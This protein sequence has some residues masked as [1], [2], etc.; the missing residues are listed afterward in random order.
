[1]GAIQGDGKQG[2]FTV[3]FWHK[4]RIVLLPFP[5]LMT[6]SHYLCYDQFVFSVPIKE[7][8]SHLLACKSF[9]GVIVCWLLK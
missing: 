3:R 5:S 4:H 9:Y 7:K 2:R 1:M 8:S 6:D